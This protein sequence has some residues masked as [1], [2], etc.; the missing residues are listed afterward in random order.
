MK[1][2]NVEILNDYKSYKKGSVYNLNG[3]LI[4]LSG[5]NGSGKSQLLKIIANNNNEKISRRITQ[6]TNTK[7]SVSLENILLLSFRD[8][9]DL[10]TDFGQFS[11]T[12]QKNNAKN[13]CV[14][15]M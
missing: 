15:M 2:I 7:E 12:Y 11:V 9:I 6:T 3:D 1:E 4:I 14:K 10:G 13:V 5:I 8:N